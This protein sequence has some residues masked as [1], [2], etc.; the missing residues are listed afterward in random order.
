MLSAKKD[1]DLLLRLG[2]TEDELS[3]EP[4]WTLYEEPNRSLTERT[5]HAALQGIRRMREQSEI[6]EVFKNKEIAAAPKED[7]LFFPWAILKE[8]A[9]L[10]SAAEPLIRESALLGLFAGAIL[11]RRYQILTVKRVVWVSII[12]LVI[13][14]GPLSYMKWQEIRDQRVVWK[15]V[16]TIKVQSEEKG[17]VFIQEAK[18]GDTPGIIKVYRSPEKDYYIVYEEPNE[19]VEKKLI[20]DSAV[21]DLKFERYD[22]KSNVRTVDLSREYANVIE[23]DASGPKSFEKEN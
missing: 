20:L 15:K 19:K 7:R 10:T 16:D 22:G 17:T 8:T 5:V 23:F 18:L 12:L 2:L 13:L 9:L 6:D 1:R 14:A 21:L 4:A 3:E 11:Q